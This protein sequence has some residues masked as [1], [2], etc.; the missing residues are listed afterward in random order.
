MLWL[1]SLPNALLPLGLQRASLRAAPLDGSGGHTQIVKQLRLLGILFRKADVGAAAAKALMLFLQEHLLQQRSYA[2]EKAHVA[3][4]F[5]PLFFRTVLANGSASIVE[6]EAATGLLVSQALA[7]LTPCSSDDISRSGG[8][9][10]K[11][12]N[13]QT[14][15]QHCSHDLDCL[16]FPPPPLPASASEEYEEAWRSD[17]GLQG[18]LC[19]LASSTVTSALFGEE[20]EDCGGSDIRM[21]D[22]HTLQHTAS[23]PSPLPSMAAVRKA[24]KRVSQEDTDVTCSIAVRPAIGAPTKASTEILSPTSP[25]ASPVSQHQLFGSYLIATAF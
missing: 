18:T 4:V 16:P 6:A 19:H 8:D 25:F 20:D 5:A 1:A 15:S 11:V 17:P 3:G 21:E 7:I 22:V 9:Q 24:V 12:F 13:E 14:T 10:Q 2:E 23:A